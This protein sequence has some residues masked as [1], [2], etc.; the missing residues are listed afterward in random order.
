MA[1]WPVRK[2]LPKS[3]R[4]ACDMKM[5]YCCHSGLSRPKLARIASRSSSVASAL[6]IMET[7][8]PI[9]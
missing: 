4:S 2:L 7:G 9:T 8:S 5:P 3:S 6:A 1:D